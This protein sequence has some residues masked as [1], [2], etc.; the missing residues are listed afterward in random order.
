MKTVHLLLILLAASGTARASSAKV[1]SL[2]RVLQSQ[3]PVDK[4]EVLWAIAYE[5]FDVDN[6]QALFYA[7]RAYHEVWAKGDS[8]QIVKV[9]TTYGQLLRRRSYLDRSMEVS[10]RLLPIAKRHDFRKYTKILLNSLAMTYH[11]LGEVDKSIVL[12]HESLDM[13]KV[14]NDSSEIGSALLNLGYMNYELLDASR[15][16]A[17]LNEALLYMN[18][19]K[20]LRNIML[21]HINL[22]ASYSLMG[23]CEVAESYYWKSISASKAITET[24]IICDVNRG[25]AW[26]KYFCGKLDSARFYALQSL[27]QSMVQMNIYSATMSS[28][29]LSKVELER[30]NYA[31]SFDYLKLADSLIASAKYPELYSDVLEQKTRYFIEIGD[32]KE[33]GKAMRLY[34]AHR[35]Q[36]KALRRNSRIRQVQIQYAQK[37]NLEKLKLQA[38]MLEFRDKA[39]STQRMFLV[40]VVALLA[41][42]LVLLM[43]LWKAYTQKKQVN[44]KLDAIVVER[45]AELVRQRDIIR[46]N[47]DEQRIV[48]RSASGEL[49]VLSNSLSGLLHLARVDKASDRGDYI[50]RAEQLVEKVKGLANRLGEE[51]H[52]HGGFRIE[53]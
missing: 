50:E 53:P 41:V 32:S 37:E 47:F 45:T 12:N 6:P 9:G 17:Y 20:D 23:Q 14:D 31:P 16:I 43:E 28:L 15:A 46:H 51:P 49:V 38:S 10:N 3:A 2:K 44:A 26:M 52:D 25:I 48:K 22:G 11:E 27:E 33:A 36:Q 4:A 34:L 5:L 7:E 1:D 39:I 18:P 19:R 35:D 13:R 30:R 40:G 29:I 21:C 24:G 42:V 8:L